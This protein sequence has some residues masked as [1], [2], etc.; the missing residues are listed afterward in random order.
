MGNVVSYNASF[1]GTAFHMAPKGFE[2]KATRAKVSS[3][4]LSS[5]TTRTS[6]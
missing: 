5:V 3:W 2:Y 6:L 1:T 4:L